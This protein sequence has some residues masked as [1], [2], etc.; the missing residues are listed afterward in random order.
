MEP[1]RRAPHTKALLALAAALALTLV[2]AAPARTELR[3]FRAVEDCG[4][5]TFRLT[6]LVPAEIESAYVHASGRQRSLH[7]S[8]VRAGVRRGLLRARLPRRPRGSGQAGFN[9]LCRLQSARKRALRWAAEAQRSGTRVH[10]H[11]HRHW[12][13]RA[14]FWFVRAYRLRRELPSRSTRRQVALLVVELKAASSGDPVIAGAGDIAGEGGSQGATADQLLNLRPSGVLTLGDNAYPD[15]TLSQ[16]ES[17]YAPTW[18]RLKGI[19]HPAPGNHE[20]A[21]GADGYFDYFGAAAGP[22]GKGFYSYDL[23][24]W[25]LISLNSNIERDGG[26]EQ[27]QWLRADLASHPTRCTLAY[28]H[29]P[30]FSSGNHGGDRSVQAFWDALDAAGADVVLA[31]HDHSYERFAPQTAAGN[32]DS[33]GVREFVVGTGGK[34]LRSFPNVQPNS[35]LRNA[36]T[37]GVLK[38]TLHPRGYEWQ[39]VP[40]AAG[41]FNDSG[42]D[43]CH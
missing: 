2:S 33:S 42:S 27:E 23:G 25:H 43:A 37:F 21:S 35:E 8:S 14:R 30:R 4:V 5:A 15:G 1:T 41:S 13:K 34:S 12:R 24:E 6:E 3:T 36:D 26:S 19:T 29:H 16:F 38:L 18:G 40:A 20:Y 10:G 9:R 7:V 39:F 11:G 17:F 32:R 28:W 31:G 22:R